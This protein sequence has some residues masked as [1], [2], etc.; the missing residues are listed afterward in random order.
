M[1]TFELLISE[2]T[3]TNENFTMLEERAEDLTFE[4][5]QTMFKIIVIIRKKFSATR[6]DN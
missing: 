3:L 5:A 2:N 4:D 6:P 1:F